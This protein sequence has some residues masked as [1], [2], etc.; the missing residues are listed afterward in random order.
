MLKESYRVLE[1]GGRVRVITPNLEKFVGLFTEKHTPEQEQ[2][3]REKTA[4]HEWPNTP[5][6]VCYVL[7]MQM[8]EW[9][10]Q[11]LYTPK[12]LR[13]SLEAA[14]FRQIRQ[15]QAGESDDAELRAIEKRSHSNVA[16]MNRFEAMVFEGVRE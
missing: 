12:L 3:L 16:A 10:H 13:A 1:P 2:Y 9:G 6:R 14:G 5:D 7:N 8:R 11:F 4:F 15:F